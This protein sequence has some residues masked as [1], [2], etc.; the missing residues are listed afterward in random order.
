MVGTAAEFPREQMHGPV[1]LRRDHWSD[2]ALEEL[3][4]SPLSLGTTGA[5]LPSPSCPSSPDSTAQGKARRGGPGDDAH[6]G[7]TAKDSHTRLSGAAKL[8][9]W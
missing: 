7:P 9:A 1:G 2:I 4:S 5:S 6:E 3:R 8:Q